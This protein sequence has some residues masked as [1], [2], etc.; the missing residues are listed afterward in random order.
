MATQTGLNILL[1]TRNS[2]QGK[3]Q[4]LPLSERLE[5]NFQTKGPKIQPAVAILISKKIDFQPKVIIKDNE[6][7]F[8]LIKGEMYQDELSILNIYAP[9][10]RAATFI[11][12]TLVKLKAHI[13][14]HKIIVGVFNTQL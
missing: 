6:G 8:I 4:T 3:R 1:L 10:T 2:P 12:V 11:K 14:P 7:Y 5:N 9:N 13:T